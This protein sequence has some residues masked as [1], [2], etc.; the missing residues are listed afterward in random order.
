[1]CLAILADRWK[2]LKARVVMYKDRFQTTTSDEKSCEKSS[3]LGVELF[4]YL[5]GKN[6]ILFKLNLFKCLVFYRC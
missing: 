6:T 4:D 5:N 3:I 2:Q 1:M